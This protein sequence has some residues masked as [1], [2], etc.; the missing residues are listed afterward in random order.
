MIDVKEAVKSARNYLMDM[1][2]EGQISTG[3]V[4]AISLEEVELSEDEKY[5]LITFG[6][7]T[8]RAVNTNRVVDNLALTK[9]SRNGPPQPLYIRNYKLITVRAEDGKPE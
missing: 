3:P 8:D 5:W 1:I 6:Y 2:H 4:P 9:L 7:D